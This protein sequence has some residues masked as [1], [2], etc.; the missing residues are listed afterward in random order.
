VIR[1]ATLCTATA[2]VAAL[3]GGCSS[4]ARTAQPPASTTAV[5]E[6]S[7]VATGSAAATSSAETTPPVSA[8]VTIGWVGDTTPGSRYGL[9][10]QHGRALFSKVRAELEVPDIMV[11]NLE[12]TFGSGGKSK[13][14]T[15]T[16][17]SF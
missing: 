13:G 7:V 16:S 8:V 2:L 9:P 12:G 3:L 15:G 10:P 11:G 4:A 1:R 6:S 17:F 14:S 5:M